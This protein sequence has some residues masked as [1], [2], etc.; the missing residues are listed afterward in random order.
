M[1]DA[2]DRNGVA[3]LLRHWLGPVTIEEFTRLSGGA[4]RQ[5]WSFDAIDRKSVV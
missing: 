5:T 1:A 2:P 4:S 3:R